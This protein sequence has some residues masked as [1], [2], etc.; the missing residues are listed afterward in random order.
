MARVKRRGEIAPKK[1]GKVTERDQAEE[2]TRVRTD[3]PQTLIGLIWRVIEDPTPLAMLIV[4][5]AAMS[6]IVSI[7]LTVVAPM[8]VHAS[9]AGSVT[10]GLLLVSVV[11]RR[12]RHGR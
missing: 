1:L 12:V 6:A 2:P 11:L 9:V 7:V 4:L 8:W 3:D 5:L 10:C